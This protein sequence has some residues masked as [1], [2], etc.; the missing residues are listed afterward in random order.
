MSDS[1]LDD[2]IERTTCQEIRDRGYV[3][4][5]QYFLG[6]V[7]LVNTKEDDLLLAEKNGQEYIIRYKLNSSLL[8][9]LRPSKEN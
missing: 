5:G 6:M 7:V 2:I 4:R 8:K 1:D 3:T 9:L